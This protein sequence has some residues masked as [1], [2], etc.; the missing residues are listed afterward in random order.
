MQDIQYNIN[1]LFFILALIINKEI[2]KI[3]VNF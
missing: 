2:V 3:K 1:K